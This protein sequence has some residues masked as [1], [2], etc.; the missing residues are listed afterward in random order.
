MDSGLGLPVKGEGP[1]LPTGGA[2]VPFGGAGVP[3]GGVG[4]GSCSQT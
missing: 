4:W 2:A 3:F 1:G